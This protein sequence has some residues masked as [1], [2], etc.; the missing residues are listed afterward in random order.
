MEKAM[1]RGTIELSEENLRWYDRDG[2]YMT[3]ETLRLGNENENTEYVVF[4]GSWTRCGTVRDCGDH[5]I[6][7]LFSGR[8]DSIDKETLVIT[9]DVE[10]M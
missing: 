7:A 5:Y 1:A 4:S 9:R 10:D 8:Y 2:Y 3:G 6:R